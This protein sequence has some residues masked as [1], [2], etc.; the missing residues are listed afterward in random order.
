[1]DTNKFFGLNFQLANNELGVRFTGFK[2]AILN[3]NLFF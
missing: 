2:A 1:V 3:D